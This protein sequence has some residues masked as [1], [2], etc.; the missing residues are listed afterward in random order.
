MFFYSRSNYL[1]VP[2]ETRKFRRCGT[3]RPLRLLSFFVVLVTI[4]WFLWTP[5][6]A[7][8]FFDSAKAEL[9]RLRDHYDIYDFQTVRMRNISLLT[10]IND[11]STRHVR[12]SLEH[13]SGMY[14]QSII[15]LLQFEW[16][17][18]SCTTILHLP[19][20]PCLRLYP[21]NTSPFRTPSH[22]PVESME[23]YHV[24]RAVSVNHFR[25]FFLMQP[26]FLEMNSENNC[27]EGGQVLFDAAQR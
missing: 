12:T 19:P 27:K 10:T 4:L 8:R 18:N 16:R 2:H 22:S 20:F 14:K 6:A 26:S 24:P 5:A 15:C 7:S 25:R 11:G 23:P 3:K 17:S 13:P 21:V 9:P 1:P